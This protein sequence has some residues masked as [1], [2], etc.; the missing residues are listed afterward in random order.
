M[1]FPP[2]DP[3][4]LW[5]LYVRPEATGG[6]WTCKMAGTY[7]EVLAAMG[8]AGREYSIRRHHKENDDGQR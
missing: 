8:G 2:A 3:W 1:K 4:P 7:Q 5:S 6:R